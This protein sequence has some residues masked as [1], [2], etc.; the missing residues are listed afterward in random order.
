M[1]MNVDPWEILGKDEI[2]ALSVA[3]CNNNDRHQPY[4]Y[5]L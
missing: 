2:A 5:Y 4:R 3:V 1:F